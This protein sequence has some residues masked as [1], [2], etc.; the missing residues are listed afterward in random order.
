MLEN[1]DVQKT[2]KRLRQVHNIKQRITKEENGNQASKSFAD[3][4]Q[5]VLTMLAE[6]DSLVQQVNYFMVKTRFRHL[7]YTVHGTWMH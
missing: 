4:V 3:E 7:F 6:S 2:A 5:H 1:D